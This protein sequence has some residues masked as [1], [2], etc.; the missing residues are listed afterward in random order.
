MPHLFLKIA[1]PANLRTSKLKLQKKLLIENQPRNEGLYI[2][3]YTLSLISVVI[4]S[5]NSSGVIVTVLLS[6]VR[7]EIF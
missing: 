1:M 7:I 5:R 3:V 6:R 2:P 4:F